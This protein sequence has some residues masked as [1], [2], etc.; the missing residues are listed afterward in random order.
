MKKGVKEE[1]RE[2]GESRKEGRWEIRKEGEIFPNS[3]VKVGH[4]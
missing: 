2:E 3:T 4:R 1:E